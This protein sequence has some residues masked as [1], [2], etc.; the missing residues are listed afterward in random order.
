MTRGPGAGAIVSGLGISAIGRRTGIS[1]VELTAASCRQAIADAGLVA[2]DVDG[3][4]SIGDTALSTAARELGIEPAYR[5]G[6]M[7]TGG[8][9]SPVMAAALAVTEG[10]ARHVLV[11]RTVNMIGGDMTPREPAENTAASEDLSA[12]MDLTQMMSDV[13][14]LLAADAFSAANWLAMHC[15]RHMSLYGTT[16]EQLGWLAINS[17]RNAALNPLAV[18]REPMTMEDYLAARMVSSPFGLYDC[19]A[20]VDG[21]IAV[22][23]SRPE[24]AADCPKPPVRVEA[25]GGASGRGGWFHRPDYPTMASADAAREMW[26]RTDLTPADIDIAQLYDGFT[27]L[28]LAWLEALG[29]CAPGESGPFV[30]GAHR[31]A[32]DGDLPLNTYGGQ[33]SA[34]RMHGYW[35]LHEACLQ[36]RGEAGERQVR[37]HPQVAVVAVGGGPIAGS[38]LLTG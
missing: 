29:I 3:I 22:V 23:I 4:T 17:R 9:L 15:R 35:V 16:K 7:T 14:D 37:S 18:Y 12:A 24:Y 31:I 36:L 5:G 26:G 8:L 27:F 13:D 11:Y 25:I 6:G 34:G 33:L 30:E 21:S 20:P 28:T 1:D 10:R 38:M 2:A 19:D 32:L